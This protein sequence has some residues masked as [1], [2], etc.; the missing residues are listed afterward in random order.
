MGPD[1]QEYYRNN[2]LTGFIVKIKGFCGGSGSLNE[3]TKF[4]KRFI[5]TWSQLEQRGF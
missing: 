2:I 4:S 1:H 5:Q 3:M